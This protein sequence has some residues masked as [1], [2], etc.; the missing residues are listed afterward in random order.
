M[1]LTYVMDEVS[2]V[3]RFAEFFSNQNIFCIGKLF[4]RVQHALIKA[5]D[6]NIGWHAALVV[7]GTHNLNTIHVGHI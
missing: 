5:A 2:G 7:E 4:G 1:Q 3:Y 6:K